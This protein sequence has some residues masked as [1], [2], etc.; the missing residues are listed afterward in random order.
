MLQLLQQLKQLA[1]PTLLEYQKKV[2]QMVL[3]L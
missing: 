3:P 2:Q 1:G